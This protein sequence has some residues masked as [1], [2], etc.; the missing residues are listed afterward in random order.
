MNPAN[1]PVRRPGLA[2]ARLE[3]TRTS[4]MAHNP[5]I[6]AGTVCCLHNRSSHAWRAYPQSW[7]GDRDI[8]ERVCEHG[9]GHPDPDDPS[10]DRQ[11]SCDGCCGD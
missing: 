1:F 2:A 11:H 10:K 8:M 3:H 4:I 9:V 5:L 6:C 7:R